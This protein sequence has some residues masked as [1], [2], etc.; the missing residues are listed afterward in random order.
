MNTPQ[1]PRQFF[2]EHHK[3]YI[4]S[5]RHAR[6]QDLGLLIKG[7][8]LKL[9]ETALDVATGSG[10][11]AIQLAISGAIVTI[12]DVTPEM[13]HDAQSLAQEQGITLHAVQAP[14]EALPFPNQ[15]FDLVTCRRAAH[16]FGDVDAFLSEARRVL[17][18]FGRLGI[19]DMTAS[20]FSLEWLNQLERLRD[21]SHHHALSPQSWQQAL[22]H[23]G[24]SDIVITRSKEPMSF[25]EWLSPVSADSASGQAALAFLQ[26][27]DAPGELVHGNQFIKHRILIWARPS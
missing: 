4:I 2:S 14:A 24:F 8:N 27:P 7:L 6:G 23:A 26:R 13:L 10:H 19:S 17:T 18:P 16:H 22:D 5:E 9:G 1:D 21:P 11:T 15:A 25:T 3:A 12:V 20:E